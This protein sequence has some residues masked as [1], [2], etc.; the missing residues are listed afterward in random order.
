MAWQAERTIISG[1]V[2]LLRI[3][4]IMWERCSGETIST[5]SL[6]S[7]DGEARLEPLGQIGGILQ[8]S[9]LKQLNN[10]LP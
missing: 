7:F 8:S 10:V 6:T 9:L 3:N 1:F 2:S 4:P 5:R